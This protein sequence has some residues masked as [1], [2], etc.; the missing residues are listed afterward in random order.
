MRAAPFDRFEPLRIRR[1]DRV[2]VLTGAGISAESGIRTFRDAGGLWE[3]YRFEEV[4]SPEGWRAHPSVVWRF[5][6]QR[7]AQAASCAPNAA[8][9]AL[10]SAEQ[11]LGERFF[12]CTQNVDD[13]HEKAGSRRLVHM[14]GELFK[15]R[16]EGCDRA[17]FA[18]REAHE[19]VPVCPC[20]ARVRP[21]IVWFGEVPFELP[22]IGEELESCSVFV[23]IGSSGA[24]YPAA[25]FVAELKARALR[26]GA[27]VRTVYVGTEEPDNTMLFDECRLG[28]AGDV[29]PGLL[30]LE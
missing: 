6:A 13:L 17:P 29:V 8:H 1:D 12:L 2:F 9:A 14:H 21:H 16:C 24:V 4:A 26:G 5:Y 25:G 19:G 30:V 20:G 15:S 10:A 28:K 22:R 7:R 11:R 18:D 23:T 27:P 3:Q